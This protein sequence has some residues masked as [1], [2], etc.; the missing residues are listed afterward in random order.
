MYPKNIEITSLSCK[1]ASRK[2]YRETLILFNYIIKTVYKTETKLSNNCF[3][4]C[5]EFL[6]YIYNITKMVRSEEKN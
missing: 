5:K 6:I 2:V 1:L 3:Y 4:L